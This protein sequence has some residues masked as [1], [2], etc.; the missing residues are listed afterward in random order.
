MD[1]DTR[2]LQTL[3]TYLNV[4]EIQFLKKQIWWVADSKQNYFAKGGVY[5]DEICFMLCNLQQ[6]WVGKQDK[7]F[8]LDFKE[9]KNKSVEANYED[10]MVMINEPLNNG[11]NQNKLKIQQIEIAYNNH[12]RLVVNFSML[13]NILPFTWYIELFQLDDF[14]I[15]DTVCRD[16]IMP[17]A[18]TLSAQEKRINIIKMCYQDLEKELLK[19]MSERE[20][21]Q[22]KK[23]LQD[24][25]IMWN[26]L[27]TENDI[28]GI[29]PSQQ[30]D[31]GTK[32][33][34]SHYQFSQFQKIQKKQEAV[35]YTHLRAH[36]TRHDLVCR[37]LLEKKKKKNIQTY[38]TYP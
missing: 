32:Y 15:V 4:D 19:R 37:L 23:K 28:S 13:L 11:F 14:I 21:Q 27:C 7:Q 16:I 36:E 22:Y 2:V 29:F 20:R 34:L 25:Q 3:S 12:Q 6:V 30:F 35:S 24:D 10:F 17:M 38:Y 18:Y 8:I 26:T 33:F 31:N 5:E 9:K 1:Q